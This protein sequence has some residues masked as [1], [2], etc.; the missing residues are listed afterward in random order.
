[1]AKPT[2][3]PDAA[4]TAETIVLDVSDSIID[5]LAARASLIADVTHVHQRGMRVVIVHG[6][7]SD[8]ANLT[9]DVATSQL[10][11]GDS[12]TDH[13]L[14]VVRSVMLSALNKSIVTALH[15]S[16]LLAV[17]LAGDDGKTF[18]LASDGAGAVSA[19]I[20]TLR[21]AAM[22]ENLLSARYVPVVASVATDTQR[23]ATVIETS[24]ASAVLAS[25]LGAR[26]LVM[27]SD[28]PGV[29]KDPT[30]ATSVMPALSSYDTEFLIADG[31]LDGR[32]AD[33]LSSAL[34]A[35][36]GGVRSV[37]M[38]DGRVPNAVADLVLHDRGEATVIVA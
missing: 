12:A 22:I 3:G 31:G 17:G 35:L 27:A 38:L 7:G 20:I 1:M 37:M 9:D 15:E 19:P 6:I 21:N 13:A 25:A 26:A 29:T 28:I 33:M 18:S 8:I 2:Q 32:I 11:S 16:G 10:A 23:H 30:N 5:D 14:D 34:R 24:G 36:D 4:M